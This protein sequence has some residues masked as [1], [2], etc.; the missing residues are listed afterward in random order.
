MKWLTFFK[1]KRTDSGQI[2]R[3][4]HWRHVA[5][6]MNLTLIKQLPKVAVPECGKKLGIVKAGTLVLSNDDEIAVVYDYCLH[7][8]RRGNKTVIER[9][10]EQTPPEPD[11]DEMTLL[12]AMSA[13][14]VSAFRITEITPR[15]GA[16]LQDLGYGDRIELT[17]LA[18]AE[19][20]IVGTV[21]VGRIVSLPGLQM[22]SGTLIPM[23]ESA[24]EQSVVPL[25]EKFIPNSGEGA[26]PRLSAAQN[27]A[28]TALLVRIALH[29][30]GEDNVFYTDIEPGH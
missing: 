1:R 8:Y 11:S 14:R 26:R 29:A 3:Y 20:G 21:V 15:A 4:K 25:I 24:Y 6:G 30:G 22:S 28:F 23:P 7:H 18:L 12:E 27:A 9:Y 10:L 17:D 13:S 16:V 19:T 5:R 2:G